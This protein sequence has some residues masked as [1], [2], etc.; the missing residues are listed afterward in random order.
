[1]D[2]EEVGG[3]GVDFSDLVQD[4]GKLRVMNSGIHKMGGILD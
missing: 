4:R 3:K 2:L 1:M